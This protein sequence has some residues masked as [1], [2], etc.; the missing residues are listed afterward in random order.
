MQSLKRTEA[1][2]VSAIV[3]LLNYVGPEAALINPAA[4]FLLGLAADVLN[5]EIPP[6]RLPCEGCAGGTREPSAK[7]RLQIA[8]APRAKRPRA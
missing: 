7:R 1:D 2:E 6:S 5:G 8:P 3:A 4:G